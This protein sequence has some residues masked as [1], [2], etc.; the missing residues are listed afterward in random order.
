MRRPTELPKSWGILPS[1]A[2]RS[3]PWADP[4]ASR[5]LLP[6]LRPQEGD[7][8][9]GRVDFSLLSTPANVSPLHPAATKAGIWP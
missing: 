2:C 3:A 5:P 8:K 7:T 6:A 9:P 4:V 1:E